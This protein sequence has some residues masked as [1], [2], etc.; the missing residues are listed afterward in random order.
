MRILSYQAERFAV[1]FRVSADWRYGVN[2]VAIA[3]VLVA[4]WQGKS[5]MAEP[6]SLQEAMNAK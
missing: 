5:Q 3:I 6:V 1:S 2:E 4:M